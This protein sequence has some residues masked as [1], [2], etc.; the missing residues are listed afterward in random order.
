VE[1]EGGVEVLGDELLGGD[2][3]LG[4]DELGGGDGVVT[5]GLVE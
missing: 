3:P 5:L 1:S 4:G 2:E